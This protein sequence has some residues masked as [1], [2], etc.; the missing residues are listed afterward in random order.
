MTI[1]LN[2]LRE[3]FTKLPSLVT[4][5]IMVYISTYYGFKNKNVS[6]AA[7]SIINLVREI[8][9]ALLERKFRGRELKDMDLTN[10]DLNGNLGKVHD[11]IPGAELLEQKGDVPVE[12]DRVFTDEDFKQMRKLMRRKKEQQ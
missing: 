3:I 10:W 2:T 8:N 1:G 5:D 11:R 7:K 6:T 9:P 4:E 12:R